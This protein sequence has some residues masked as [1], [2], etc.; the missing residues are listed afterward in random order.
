MLFRDKYIYDFSSHDTLFGKQILKI[1]SAVT[2]SH[3]LEPSMA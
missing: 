3:F 1:I 2:L